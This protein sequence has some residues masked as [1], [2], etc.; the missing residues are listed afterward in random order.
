[1][2]MPSIQWIRLGLWAV[3]GLFLVASGAAGYAIHAEMQPSA[4]VTCGNGITDL[5]RLILNFGA[6]LAI[7][8]ISSLA[9][10]TYHS[11]GRVLPVASAGILCMAVIAG[12]AAFG[13]R[14]F[15]DYLPGHHLSRIVWWMF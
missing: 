15:H 4:D 3:I 13:I 8:T 7:I 5:L 1:M 11:G 2:N 6:P 9:C 12:F 10:L 14:F